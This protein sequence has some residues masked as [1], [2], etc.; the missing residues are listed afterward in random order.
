MLGLVA[1]TAL[2]VSAGG[3]A[4]RVTPKHVE[5]AVAWRWA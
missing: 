3:C 5:L 2:S 4:A 1:L